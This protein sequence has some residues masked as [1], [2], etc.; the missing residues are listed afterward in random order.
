LD[1]LLIVVIRFFSDLWNTRTFFQE[2]PVFFIHMNL[3]AFLIMYLSPDALAAFHLASP[4]A[5]GGPLQGHL[6][7]V[8]YFLRDARRMPFSSYPA[9]NVGPEPAVIAAEDRPRCF[10]DDIATWLILRVNVASTGRGML[11]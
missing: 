3:G 9:T 1:S 6:L 5:F 11:G 7:W 10:Q 2:F 4:G 8:A